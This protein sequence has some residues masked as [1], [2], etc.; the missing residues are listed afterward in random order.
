VLA[1]ANDIL[2]LYAQYPGRSVESLQAEARARGEV[3]AGV[4]NRLVGLGVKV[5]VSDLPDLGLS[6]FARVQKA[7]DPNGPDRAAVI[8]SLAQAFSEQ[9][10]VKVILDGRYVGL[11]QAQL[12]FRS[13]G[14]S[15]GSFG[16]ANITD[17]ACT[18]ALP[19]CTTATLLS[20]ADPTSFLWADDTRLSPGGQSQLATLAVDRARRNPF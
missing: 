8:T 7:L 12:R 11:V 4:V 20:G 14:V 15:P 17:A 6:P 3:L 1:G 10:G 18:L 9:L 5:I 19:N 13:I 16:L 2:D